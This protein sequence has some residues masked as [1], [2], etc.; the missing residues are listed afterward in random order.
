MIGLEFQVIPK[1]IASQN[2]SKMIEFQNAWKSNDSKM[3][4]YQN[5]SKMIGLQNNRNGKTTT[6][7]NRDESD[8]TRSEYYDSSK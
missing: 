6:A 5:D 4:G 2:D 1:I 7:K 3:I 8:E